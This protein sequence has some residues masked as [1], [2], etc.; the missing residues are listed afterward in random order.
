MRLKCGKPQSRCG[1]ERKMKMKIGK[2]KNKYIMNM[3]IKSQRNCNW[4]SACILVFREYECSCEK[5]KN[6]I[7][8]CGSRKK[9]R[10]CMR[11]CI[12]ML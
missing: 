12:Y 11:Q 4:Y 6:R 1:H 3:Y 10:G 7:V 2:E 5:G 8:S 9:E